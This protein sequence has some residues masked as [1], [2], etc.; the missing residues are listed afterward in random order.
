MKHNDGMRFPISTTT[1]LIALGLLSLGCSRVNEGT[2][3]PPSGSSDLPNHSSS[4]D[5]SALDAK[6]DPRASTDEPQNQGEPNGSRGKL[7][8]EI[9]TEGHE[10]GGGPLRVALYDGPKTFNKVDLAKWK[11]G[12]EANGQPIQIEL[13]KSLFPSNELAVAVYQD[14]NSNNQL[15]KNAFGIPQEAYGFSNNPKRGFG[16]PKYAEVA[17][18]IPAE[19]LGLTIKLQ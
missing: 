15:D 18:P 5:S 6:V 12:F 13:E 9:V 11:D 16:P 14:S 4:Q 19:K 2:T 7:S 8:V 3:N 17:V 1:L 10:M